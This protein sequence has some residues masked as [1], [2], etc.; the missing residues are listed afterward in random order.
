[1]IK[2]DGHKLLYH[3]PTLNR[4][5]KGEVIYPILVEI[6]PVGYCNQ[7]CIFCAYNYLKSKKV[8]LKKDKLLEI[9]DEFSKLGV[10][11]I[12]FS[13]EGEP[14]LHPDIAELINYA[15]KK[16][17]DV[18]LNTNGLLLKEELSEKILKDL[19]WVRFSINAGNNESYRRIHQSNIDAFQVV[20]DNIK[21][22]AALK[23]KNKLKVTLG[24]QCV[25]IGQPLKEL[26]Q[27]GSI[28]KEIGVDYFAVKPFNQHPL[29]S[30]KPDK[31]MLGYDEL[32]KIEELS[33]DNFIAVV[34]RNFL[35]N[36][37]DRMYKKCYGLEFF[38]EIESNGDLCPCG[39]LL[40]IKEYSYG[41]VYKNSFQEIWNSQVRK[42]I[43][44]KIYMD[45]DISLCME[46]C[47]L[48][49]VNNFLWKIKNEPMH[50]NFI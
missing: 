48:N 3:L 38:A 7:K 44:K 2:L 6:S 15:Y 14:L 50:V 34:R 4:W 36:E 12:F 42:D 49:S 1:M 24:V 25:Y 32:K 23:K 21:K 10:K 27:L 31:K 47:R 30:F 17:I 40:G 5:R 37:K 19:T 43:L 46:N 28:L 39:P 45:F 29:I 26:L 33:S 9:I 22:A 41:N 16:G 13:G 35:A 18:A 8:L 11:S 20:I